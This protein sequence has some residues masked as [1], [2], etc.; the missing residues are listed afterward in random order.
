MSPKEEHTFSGVK[1]IHEMKI[2]RHLSVRGL[3][4]YDHAEM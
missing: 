1:T 4:E 2:Q 3:P